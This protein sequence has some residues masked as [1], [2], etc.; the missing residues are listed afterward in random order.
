MSA[1]LTRSIICSWLLLISVSSG[2]QK[3]QTGGGGTPPVGGGTIVEQGAA[4]DFWL[5]NPDQ[6]ALFQ[7]QNTHLVFANKTNSLAT[8]TVDTTQRFQTMDG[9]GFTLTGGSAFLISQLPQD[10]KAKLLRELFS[11]DSA[12]IGISYL[13]VSIGA[14]DLNDSAFTYDDLPDGQTDATLQHFN[15]GEDRQYLIPLLQ[16][17]IQINPAIS[18][19]STPW[20]APS[21]MKSNNSSIGGTLLPKYYGVYAQYFVK[22]IQQMKAMGITVSAVTPQNEPLNPD[23]NPSMVMSDTAEDVFVKNYLGPAF[24]QAEIASKIII[25]DHN[26]DRPD[27]PLYILSDN[28]ANPYVDG[29]A[30]HLYAGNISALSQVHDA[31]PEKNLYFT[32]QYT[33]SNGSF[34]GD[35]SWH[36]QNLIIGAT[37]NWSKNVLEWNLASD[38]AYGPHTPGGCTTCKGAL[39]IGRDI[40]R[41]VSYYIITAASKFVRPGAV[42]VGSNLTGPFQNVAFQNADGTKVLIVFNSGSANQSFNISFNG[43][44]TTANLNPGAV[45]TFVWK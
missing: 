15:F 5:T 38:P 37:R 41:N 6:S 45:G 16:D 25:Y 21:W 22:Y 27:Y 44:T 19:I 35:L 33:P 28:D 4:V 32:E 42:R 12:A 31:Y 23:N 17:I 29:S 39:T 18:I 9:F 13:R 36:I 3:Q 34:A 8:I 1:L 24:R 26:C 40:E 30:F 10:Q 20:S 14:S 11:T 7:K 2:C 43:M